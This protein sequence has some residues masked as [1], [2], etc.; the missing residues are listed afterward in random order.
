MGYN[1][2]CD[3]C[4]Q[5]SWADNIVD[6]IDHHLDKQN[7]LKCSN[8]GKS[9]AY[10]YLT[11]PTQDGGVWE[12][13]VRGVI[14]IDYKEEEL[15]NYHPYVFLHTH[16]GAQGEVDSVQISYYKDHRK[17]RGGVLKHGH[18]PGGTPVLDLKDIKNILQKLIRLGLMSKMA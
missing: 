11:S 10:I 18:G 13:W 8:C 6:L 4:K 17:K 16:D 9:G 2:K 5:P 3:K 15:K 14:R 1:I 7:F 12:R